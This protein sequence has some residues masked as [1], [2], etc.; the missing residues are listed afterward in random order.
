MELLNTK[1]VIYVTHQLEFLEASDLV[2][3]MKNGRI[4]QSGKYKDLMAETTGELVTQMDAHSKSLNQVKPPKKFYKSF[5]SHVY[6]QENQSEDEVIEEKVHNFCHRD[7]IQEKSQ[8]EETETGRVKWHVYS[9]FATC[10]YKGALVPLILLCQVLFQALQMASIYWIAWGTEKE[11]RVSKDKLIGIFSLMSG[12]SSI[13]ILGRAVLLSTIAIE[14]AQRLF[15]GIITSVFRAP[16][17]FFDSTSSSRILN[18]S[19]TDQ[20]IVDT[21]IPYRLAFALIQLLSIVV[22]MS[23]VAWE[24]PILFLVVLAIS[25]CYQAYY[26]TTARELARMVGIRKAPILHHFSESISGA[27]TI[28]C[29][30]QEDRFLNRNII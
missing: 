8:Q 21:D 24:V 4:V 3:V 7:G 2:L 20:S 29:F 28:R 22:L 19:S 6:H 26:I 10:A 15:Q 25:I 18:R 30:N 17:S 23:N 27:S 11:G 12:G 5:S 1:T 9:T 16:L 13:F 14:T